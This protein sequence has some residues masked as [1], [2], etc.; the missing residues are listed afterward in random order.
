MGSTTGSN[1]LFSKISRTS[2]KT[3]QVNLGYKCN[4]ACSHCHVDAGPKRTE[5]MSRETIEE[6]LDFVRREKI[7]ELDITGGAPELNPNFRY[8]VSQATLSGT[9]VI[10]RCN[11]TVLSEP[12]QMTLASFLAECEVKVIA[13]MP[14]YSGANV[15]RQRGRGVFKKSVEGIRIL[16]SVGYADPAS[17]LV[18]DLVYNPIG[19]ILPPHPSVLEKDYRDN[20]S[21]MDLQFN[22]LITMTNMPIKRFKKELI[23]DGKLETYL[24]LLTE[25]FE[26]SNLNN[27]MCRS[28]LS[29]DWQGYVYDCDFNQMLGIKAGSKGIRS[30]SEIF[31][32]DL[33]GEVIASDTHCYGCLAG[34]GSSCSGAL[35]KLT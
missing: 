21:A 3:L 4:Q 27:V 13:S 10:D 16:N 9:R 34:R 8:L 28:T 32:V 31:G 2:L 7:G 24:R 18:L 15:D 30:I 11:L 35:N 22:S 23:R 12:G 14:C 29:V 6:V 26:S 1:F 17:G 33:E 20:F 25:N 19:P 5:E